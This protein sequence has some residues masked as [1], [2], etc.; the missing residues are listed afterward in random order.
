MRPEGPCPAVRQEPPRRRQLR[1]A[2]LPAPALSPPIRRTGDEMIPAA[3]LVI[4]PALAPVA[5]R[6]TPE[7]AG[8][9][10]R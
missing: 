9:R 2:L 1:P 4:V 8:M 3:I 6:R 5:L 10:L 7:T